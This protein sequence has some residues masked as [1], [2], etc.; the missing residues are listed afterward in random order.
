RQAPAPNRSFSPPVWQSRRMTVEERTTDHNAGYS[1]RLGLLGWWRRRGPGFA[2]GRQGLGILV[3]L[4]FTAVM[5]ARVCL[6]GNDVFAG[7]VHGRSGGLS[8]W[9]RLQGGLKPGPLRVL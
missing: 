4:T 3:M 9:L 8:L 2:D 7:T 1:R 6:G 5:D